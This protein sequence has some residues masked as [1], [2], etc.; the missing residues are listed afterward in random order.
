MSWWM[1]AFGQQ[2]LW[3]K[4]KWVDRRVV[5]FGCVRAKTEMDKGVD[6][7]IVVCAFLY[8]EGEDVGG[9]AVRGAVEDRELYALF[10]EYERW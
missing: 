9:W 1:S 3:T 5:V 6:A 10:C 4:N 2:C 7:Q 8:L